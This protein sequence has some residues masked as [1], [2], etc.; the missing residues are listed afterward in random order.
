MHDNEPVQHP[1]EEVASSVM[2]ARRILDPGAFHELVQL[3]REQVAAAWQL[4]LHQLVEQIE[5]RWQEE[6]TRIFEERFQRLEEQAASMF[7]R[8]VEDAVRLKVEGAVR[9]AVQRAERLAYQQLASYLTKLMEST[10][11]R[12]VYEE[13]FIEVTSLATKAVLFF[14][15]GNWA[16]AWKV[17][18]LEQSPAF[19]RLLQEHLLVEGHAAL[20]RALRESQ[21]VETRRNAGQLPELVVDALGGES[22][23]PGLVVAVP[24]SA[25][26]HLL[27]YAEGVPPHG[28]DKLFVQMW[29]A[30]A[31][32]NLRTA[33][34]ERGAGERGQLRLKRWQELSKE[35]RD[36]HLRAQRFA[37]VRVAEMRLYH[38]EKVKK[39]REDKNLYRA[40]KAEIDRARQEFMEKFISVCPSMV[41]YL[42]LELLEVLAGDDETL[43]GSDYPGPLG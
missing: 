9:E 5:K 27:L 39:G 10:T 6:L 8:A 4:Q 2:A 1:K 11:S 24:A 20:E 18:G 19:D 35:E 22:G 42:H 36:L 21:L 29:I 23:E 12:H 17:Y 13:F 28:R 43:L 34:A 40:L 31:A 15:S 37:R 32:S 7:E 30:A 25:G 26:T 3:A 16:K 33:Q 38:A 14:A 41:D